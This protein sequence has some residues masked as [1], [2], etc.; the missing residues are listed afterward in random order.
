MKGKK[1]LSENLTNLINL[2]FRTIP[3][4]YQ[5]DLYKLTNQLPNNPGLNYAVIRQSMKVKYT[6]LKLSRRMRQ[7]ICKEI[8]ASAPTVF[9]TQKNFVLLE[10]MN[11][12]IELLKSAGLME[13]WDLKYNDNSFVDVKQQSIPL[14]MR[15]VKSSF[16]ILVLGSLLSLILILIEKV[17]W[18]KRKKLEKRLK[19]KFRQKV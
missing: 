19:R 2:S 8:F 15:H 3:I 9:Y 13:Y 16:V 10:E 11:D 5:E 6:N 18:K 12:K 14:D 7:T 1:K 4:L 17:T